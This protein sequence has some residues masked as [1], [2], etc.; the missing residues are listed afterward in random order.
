MPTCDKWHIGSMRGFS[1]DSTS[2]TITYQSRNWYVFACGKHCATGSRAGLV[3]LLVIPVARK[4]IQCYRLRIRT[5]RL[6]DAL[7]GRITCVNR[8][9]LLEGGL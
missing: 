5:A 4:S 1:L 3:P 8:Y 9:A 6:E 2:I 7:Q